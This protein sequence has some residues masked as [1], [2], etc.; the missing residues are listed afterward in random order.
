MKT[1]AG[2]GCGVGWIRGGHI[3]QEEWGNMGAKD[4]TQ[5][6]GAEGLLWGE[7]RGETDGDAD[8]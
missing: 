3:S 1:S 2:E 4:G 6:R 8:I 7:E 5:E